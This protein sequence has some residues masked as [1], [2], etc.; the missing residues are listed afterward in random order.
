MDISSLR[1]FRLC[2][3]VVSACVLLSAIGTGAVAVFQ[4]KPAWFLLLFEIV[5]AAAG[6]FGVLI[7]R[8]RFQNGPA[9]ALASVAVCV[10]AA[11][12]L[13]FVGAG[14]AAGGFS[15]K[16]WFLARL[17]AAAVFAMAAGGILLARSGK[18][19]LRSLAVGLVLSAIFGGLLVGAM[20]VM[21]SKMW[22]GLPG[23]G[24]V[25][26]VL[27]AGAVLLAVFS[28]AVHWVIRAFSLGAQ[29]VPARAN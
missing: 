29:P 10:G 8:G 16:G 17:F 3:L 14:Q 24:R 28:A 13:G 19:A 6:V 12:L 26:I 20:A 7:A 2:I 11:S 23:A 27:A 5:V 1:S 4:A 15:L 18:P 9:I 22:A 25:A 21:G